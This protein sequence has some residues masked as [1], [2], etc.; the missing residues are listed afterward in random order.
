MQKLDSEEK[1]EEKKFVVFQGPLKDR[2]GKERVP[3]G[4]LPTYDLIENM[5]WLVP[6]V[7]GSLPKG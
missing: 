5:N 6:G 3:A 2:E 7:E 4:K 1:I